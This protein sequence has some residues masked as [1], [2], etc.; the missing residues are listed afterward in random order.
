MA[1]L[2]TPSAEYDALY[3]KLLN[4]NGLIRELQ[5]REGG[6]QLGDYFHQLTCQENPI[7]IIAK[8]N[9][10]IPCKP[11]EVI[12]DMTHDNPSML[13]KFGNRMLALP[14][15]ALLSNAN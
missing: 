15:S 3:T 8:G 9:S 4:I 14:V 7:G 2:F 1:E 5:N 12:Y 10:L 6:G 13:D 11:N